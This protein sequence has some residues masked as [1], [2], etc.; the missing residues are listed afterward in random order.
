MTN[1]SLFYQDLCTRKSYA[2]K[3]ENKIILYSLCC[4]SQSDLLQ[5]HESSKDRGHGC[6][7]NIKGDLYVESHKIFVLTCEGLHVVCFF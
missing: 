3:L 4:F 5:Q 1:H 7:Y 6:D 2:I